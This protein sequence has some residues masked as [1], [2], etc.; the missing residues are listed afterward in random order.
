M[1]RKLAWTGA[2]LSALYLLSMGLL[3]DPLPFLDES[4][5][6]AIFLK[7]SQFLGYDFRKYIPFLRKKGK[8]GSINPLKS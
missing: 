4:I 8:Y 2:V 3:P 5:A 1:K 7:C 6:I